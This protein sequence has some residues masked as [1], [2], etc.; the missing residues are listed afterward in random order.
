[1]QDAQVKKSLVYLRSKRVVL[2]QRGN[3]LYG[4]LSNLT[5]LV[6]KSTNHKL[7]DILLM[8]ERQTFLIHDV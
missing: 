4:V 6:L 8:R 5:G 3:Q 2:E 7:E 1:M